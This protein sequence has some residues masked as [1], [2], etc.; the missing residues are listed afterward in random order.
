MAQTQTCAED[1]AADRE[2]VGAI[3]ESDDS[4]EIVTDGRGAEKYCREDI[5]GEFSGVD[6]GG[7]DNVEEER[8][9]LLT[10]C[11]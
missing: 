4:M 10:Y 6:G 3:K 5:G 8:L 7:G 9:T 11:I 2:G 1:V